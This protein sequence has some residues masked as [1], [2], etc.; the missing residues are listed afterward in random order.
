MMLQQERPD[1]YVIA[2]GET[3]PVQE[4]L[5]LAFDRLSLDWKK[6]VEIDPRFFRPS[7]VDILIGDAAKARRTLEWTPRVTFAQLTAMMVDAD[8]EL[9]RRELRSSQA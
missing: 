7:E 6:H 4:F 5:E 2:T 3:H 9:A 8:L 1:D